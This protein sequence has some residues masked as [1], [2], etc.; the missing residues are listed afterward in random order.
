MKCII[1][2]KVLLKD[3]VAENLAI[4]M[5]EKIQK[6]VN[7]DEINLSDYQVIDAK[8]NYVAPGLCDMHIHG[9]LGA[10]VSDGDADG[11]RL[12]ADGIAK[13]GVTA[14][15]PTTMTV[16]KQEIEAAFD[17]VREVKNTRKDYVI[18]WAAG[19]P[20]AWDDE[21]SILA[22]ELRE[23]MTARETYLATIK[24]RQEEYKASRNN[25][26]NAIKPAVTAAA[27]VQTGSFNF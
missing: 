25:S 14:W 12:M 16:S 4:I 1:G 2:G 17:A 9:Y 23:A 10:D 19:E 13:N 15:C 27:S 6:I 22:T 20:Y 24:K 18:T 8:G 11:I 21:G 7:A 26:N 5:D 3:K